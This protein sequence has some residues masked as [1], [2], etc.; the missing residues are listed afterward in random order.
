MS[1]LRKLIWSRSLP[2]LLAKTSPSNDLLYSI[3][4]DPQDANELVYF[5]IT[6]VEH[7]LLSRLGE[8]G[9]PDM[10]LGATVGELGC[11]IDPS[12]TR[13]VQTGIEHSRIPD[14]G[15]YFGLGRVSPPTEALLAQ[16]TPFG[17][18][19]ALASAALNRRAVDYHL[20]L[21]I[22]LKGARGIGKATV[23]SWVAQRLG[24][25]LLEVCHQSVSRL[26]LLS[27]NLGGLLRC[28]RRE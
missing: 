3:L 5:T 7:N 23:A 25:H 24:I 19:L 21:S 4:D 27:L 12:I 11:W 17:K 6:N 1:P 16:E 15:T 18:L 26:Y 22:L 2:H 9:S 13:M 20:Q 8:S 10:Y 14:A 28:H